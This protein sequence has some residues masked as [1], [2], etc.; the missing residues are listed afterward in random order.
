MD[1]LTLFIRR[2]VLASMV[3]LLLLVLG[4]FS[5]RLLGVD[6]M[7]K[8]DFPMVTVTTVLRGASPEEVESQ[9]SKPIEEVVN[10]ISGIDELYAYNF[11]GV[12]RVIVRFVLERPIAEAVQ[13]VRDKV[14]TAMARLPV[15]TDPPVVSRVDFDSDHDAVRVGRP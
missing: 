1:A 8:I 9:V 11:E 3:T 12:S 6:L 13:D 15:G 7:P 5:Y 4:F 2:P 14:A 10:T